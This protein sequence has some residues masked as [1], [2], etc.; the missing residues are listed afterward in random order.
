MAGSITISS[1]TLDSDNNFSIKSNTGAT[2]FS[3]NGAG[4]NVAASIPTSSITNDKL[5]TPFSTGKA[6]AMSIVFS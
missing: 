5:A 3:S 1:I 2:L 4:I 6:I